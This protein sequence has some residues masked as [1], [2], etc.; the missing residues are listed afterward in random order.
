MTAGPADGT[1]ENPSSKQYTPKEKGA[2]G[3]FQYSR[4]NIY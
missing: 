4:G 2:Q 3:P 1:L